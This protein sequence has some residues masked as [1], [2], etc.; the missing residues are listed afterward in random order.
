MSWLASEQTMNS[1][2]GRT[3]VKKVTVLPPTS[4]KIEPNVGMLRPTKVRM[5][6]M[7]V[8][9]TQRFQLKAEK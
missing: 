6:M 4:D 5:T 8:L 9:N 7:N 1:D 3:N 2:G